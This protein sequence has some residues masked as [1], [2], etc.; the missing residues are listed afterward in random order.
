MPFLISK[1][2]SVDFAQL[3]EN[4]EN[5]LTHFHV[6]MCLGMYACVCEHMHLF[7]LAESKWYGT[8]CVPEVILNSFNKAA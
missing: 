8:H 7:G 6:C 1:C 3:L 2:S 5:S 4:V